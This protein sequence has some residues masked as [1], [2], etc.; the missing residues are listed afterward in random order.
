MPKKPKKKCKT[1]Y[2]YEPVTVKDNVGPCKRFPPTQDGAGINTVDVQ[3]TVRPDD[4]CG[5]YK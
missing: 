2:F 4:W 1:C 5:E 3:P